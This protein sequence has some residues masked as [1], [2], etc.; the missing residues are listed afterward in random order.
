MAV[1]YDPSLEPALEQDLATPYPA[2]RLILLRTIAVL[3]C[4]L[5]TVLLFGLLVP[6]GSPYAWLLPAVGFVA[7]VLAASTWVSPLRAA[8][9]VAP[10]GSW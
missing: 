3:A 9:A 6:G 4:A 10:A 7:A 8:I 1:S 2:I 5:P